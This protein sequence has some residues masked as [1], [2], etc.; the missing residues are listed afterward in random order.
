MGAGVVV[1]EGALDDLDLQPLGRKAG[2][3]ENGVDVVDDAG[4]LEL[5]GGEVDADR[6]LRPCEAVDAGPA[7]HPAPEVARHAASLRLDREIGRRHAP[8]G[9]VFQRTSAS[10]DAMRAPSGVICADTGA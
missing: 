1:D 4:I 10:T 8:P 9:R 7:Q 3:G 6:D 5:Q 2:F